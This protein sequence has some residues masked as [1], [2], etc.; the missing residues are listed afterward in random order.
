ML[1]MLLNPINTRRARRLRDT[2]P[3]RTV[4]V[5]IPSTL[6]PYWKSTAHKEF[7][8]IPRDAF[9]FTYAA[10]ALLTFFECVRTG[11]ACALPSKAADSVW[12]AWLHM[13]PAS[14]DVFC[15][16]HY[17]RTIPH[18]ESAA[19]PVPVGIGLANCLVEARKLEGI[20]PEG[21]ELPKLFAADRR[22][23]MPDGYS[24]AV[25]RG[26]VVSAPMDKRGEQDGPGLPQPALAPAALLAAGMIGQD[27]HTRYEELMLKHQRSAYSGCG[28]TGSSCGSVSCDGGGGDGGDGGGCG[29]GCGGGGD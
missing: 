25:V 27:D 15:K 3:N 4:L 10:D 20:H 19:M 29:S 14:L 11:K 26:K 28:S 18:L 8:G 6:Y 22:L 23:R 24:Y 17:G 13:S 2:S 12:H 16:K 1:D 21:P 9:F 5:D 7:E